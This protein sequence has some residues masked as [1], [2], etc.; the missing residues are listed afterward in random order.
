[1]SSRADHSTGSPE[2]D[3]AAFAAV[4]SMVNHWD[5]PGW[6]P[7]RTAYYWYLAFGDQAEVRA[8]AGRCQDVVAAPYFDLVDDSELHM[9]LERVAFVEDIDAGTLQRVRR[10][11][12]KRLAGFGALNIAIGPLAG[13][14]G[15]LSFSAEPRDRLDALRSL[16]VLANQESGIP[17]ERDP[18]PFRPH[19]GIAYCNQ[20]IDAQEII[21]RVETLRALPTVTVCIREVLLVA[22]TRKERSYTWEAVHRT[23]LVHAPESTD[24]GSV[25]NVRS[26]DPPSSTSSS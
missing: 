12:D 4:G 11:V 19:V 17:V 9:T 26:I 16:L 10:S 15:A 7:G 6:R 5:R 24:Q 1:V 3:W 21:A 20:R 14:T 18:T 23:P 2:T 8:L 22:L 13:S 25:T